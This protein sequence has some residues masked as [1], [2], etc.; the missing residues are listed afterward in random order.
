MTLVPHEEMTVK[1]VEYMRERQ[2]VR[3]GGG[4]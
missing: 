4:C 1:R 2:E 3:K